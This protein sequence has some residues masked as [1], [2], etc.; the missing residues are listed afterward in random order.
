MTSYAALLRAVNLGPHNKVPMSELRLMLS[1]LG[2]KDA[3]TLLASGNAV[4]RSD[5]SG[6][7]DLEQRLEAGCTKHFK[8]TTNF[9]VRTLKDLDAVIAANPFPKQAKED[10]GHLL[11]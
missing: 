9:F 7:A 5:L 8:L 1:K 10:P 2:M 4:F 11:V 6:A 3:Q